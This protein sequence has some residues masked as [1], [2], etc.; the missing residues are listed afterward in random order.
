[1]QDFAPYYDLMEQHK[2]FDKIDRKNF[3]GLL[4]DCEAKIIPF[5]EGDN[6]KDILDMKP[7]RTFGCV[8]SGLVQVFK[9]DAW[10]N[11]PILDIHMKNYLIGCFDVF[12]NANL[13]DIH[14]KAAKAGEI[15]FLNAELLENPP[16]DV[17]LKQVIQVQHNLI[18]ILA[19][20][21]WRMI[22]KIDII[23]AK[24]LREKVLRMLKF[25]V[26]IQKSFD[27]DIPFNR[28][29]FA[30]YIYV[31]RC[32]LSRELSKM[33]EDGLILYKKNHFKILQPAKEILGNI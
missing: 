10:G 15:L 16:G 13:V 14:V 32:A 26:L 31:D 4:K 3:P 2:L 12:Y 5:K 1:M 19:E 20:T 9:N 23:S 28:R 33:K 29:E 24:T 8:L 25:E 7:G 17:D 11:Q 18:T 30:D 22:Q 27:F 6:I 21:N